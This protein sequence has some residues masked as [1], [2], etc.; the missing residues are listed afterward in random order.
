MEAFTV[1]GPNTQL[2][3]WSLSGK[4]YWLTDSDVIHFSRLFVPNTRM[5]CNAEEEEEKKLFI[6][7]KLMRRLGSALTVWLTGDLWEV[8]CRTRLKQNKLNLQGSKP[9][10]VFILDFKTHTM[11]WLPDKY[12]EIFSSCSPLKAKEQLMWEQWCW[13][14]EQWCSSAAQRK[15]LLLDK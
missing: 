10:Q 8:Q 14:K 4:M 9:E 6:N 1:S 7:R 2:F 3:D 5:S 11:F 15:V 12:R 13:D